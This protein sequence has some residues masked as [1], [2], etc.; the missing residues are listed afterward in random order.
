MARS[1]LIALGTNELS[2]MAAAGDASAVAELQRRANKPNAKKYA[3]M[4][5]AKL[6][7]AVTVN[8]TAPATVPAQPVATITPAAPAE[9]TEQ[10]I[11]DRLYA[12]YMAAQ[13]ITFT[14]PTPQV[15]DAVKPTNTVPATRDELKAA[16]G[17]PANSRIRT[18]TMRE[19]LADAASKASAPAPTA[20]REAVAPDV[21]QDELVTGLNILDTITDQGWERLVLGKGVKQDDGSYTIDDTHPLTGLC[22]TGETAA[23]VKNKFWDEI[24][25]RNLFLPTRAQKWV[26]DDKRSAKGQR[27]HRTGKPQASLLAN[28]NGLV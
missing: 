24:K 17:L 2:Q 18:A 12:E 1:A 8:T 23:E 6:G 3:G 7:I 14:P 25:S 26:T 5:L 10:Q 19:M 13:N 11:K 4:A 20:V 22:V 21:Q 16:L 15:H 9:E 27:K 28:L